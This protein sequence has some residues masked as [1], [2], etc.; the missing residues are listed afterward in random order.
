MSVALDSLSLLLRS[1]RETEQIRLKSA[2]AEL[3]YADR[4]RERDYQMAGTQLNLASAVNTQ[5]MQS[6]ASD[7]MSSTG[8]LNYYSPTT[9]ADERSS[10]IEEF[11][12]ILV[13]KRRND[14]KGGYGFT[15]SE[16]R[17]VIGA[18]WANR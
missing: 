16:A 10:S 18:V 8:F 6:T 7:F 13:A 5:L 11:K 3:E 1:H 2:L 4:Q 12:D 9:D 17:R 15:E 14:G